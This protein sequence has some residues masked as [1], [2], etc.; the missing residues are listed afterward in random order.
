MYFGWWLREN[1][2][3]VTDTTDLNVQTFAGSNGLPSTGIEELVGKA[4]FKG[5][6][7]GK[8]AIHD[9]YAGRVGAGHFTADAELK[10]NFGTVAD[11][12]VEGAIS[13]TID[14]FVLNGSGPPESG[15]WSIALMSTNLEDDVGEMGTDNEGL[16]FTTADDTFDDDAD[17]QND[18]VPV[19]GGTQWTIG[20]DDD[21]ITDRT[22]LLAGDWGGT[23]HQS[24]AAG[25]SDETPGYAVGEFTAEFGSIGRM[26]GAFGTNNVTEDRDAPQ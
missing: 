25:R 7:A 8:W 4:T 15:G 19:L 20:G 26:V 12:G 23:F 3:P 9:D 22:Q 18:E 14:N 21:A 6:A 24:T 5:S 17:P 13:G 16:H 2:A 11:T 1:K 10:A